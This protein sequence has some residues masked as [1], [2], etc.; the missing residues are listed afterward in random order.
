VPSA[1]R[2]ARIFASIEK[3]TL[4]IPV[5]FSFNIQIV[6]YFY[7]LHILMVWSL[8]PEAMILASGEKTTSFTA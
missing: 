6:R 1:L 7:T 2:E 3:A 4:Q 8:L 5:K